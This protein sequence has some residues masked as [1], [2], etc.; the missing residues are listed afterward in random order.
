M[1]KLY[2]RE[3]VNPW[4]AACGPSCPPVPLCVVVRRF[5]PLMYLMGHSRRRRHFRDQAVTD[6]GIAFTGNQAY[7]ELQR[8]VCLGD[9]SVMD[10]VSSA[11]PDYADK[12]APSTSTS[13]ASTCLR[14][15]P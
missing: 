14:C 4:A 5:L 3:K 1:Q 13:L 11:I 2:E 7:R 6:A 10:L 8:P 15:P 12:P 9:S